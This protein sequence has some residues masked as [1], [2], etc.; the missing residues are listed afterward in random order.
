MARRA[1][2]WTLVDRRGIKRV[3]FTFQGCRYEITTG[4]RDRAEAAPI[5]ARIYADVVA[6]RLN[7]SKPGLARHPSTPLAELCADWLAAIEPELG[8]DTDVTYQVYARHWI[9]FFEVI[10]NVTTARAADYARRRLRSVKSATV[11]KELSALRR[12]LLWCHD[13]GVLRDLPEIRSVPRK[14]TGTSRAGRRQAAVELT[15]E[16]VEA[17][18]AALPE[19]SPRS[20]DGKHFPVRARFVFAFETGLRPATLDLLEASDVTLAGLHIRPELDKNRWERVVPLTE[21]ARAA[22]ASLGKL[23]PNARLFGEH[24]YRATWRA[25]CVAALGDELGKRV[26]PYDLK[27]ARVTSWLDEGQSV[28]G[29]QFLTGTRYALDRYAHAS[30]RAAEGIVGAVSGAIVDEDCAKGGNR[31]PMGVTPLAPQGRAGAEPSSES[32]AKSLDQPSNVVFLGPDPKTVPAV[33]RVALLKRSR[34]AA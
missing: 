30:R 8:R 32:T 7:P 34:G 10:G 19:L 31:T 18:L 13:E 12:F 28:L 20:K 26:N 1:Q 5:A 4:K 16:Q 22:V 33:V 23:D 29:I 14:S 24:D 2:G 21:R 17:V 27:H 3:R 11:T 25:A 9:A 6:G 15:V